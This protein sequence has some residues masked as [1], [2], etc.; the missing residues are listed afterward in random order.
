MRLRTLTGLER[1]RIEDEYQSLVK[2]IAELTEFLASDLKQFALIKTE[3]LAIRERYGDDR[4]TEIIPLEDEFNI[5]DMIADTE[6]VVT[7]TMGGYIKRVSV[8]T[9]RAQNRGG[10]GVTGIALK[11][12]DVV[13]NFFIASTHQHILF[14]T[15]KGRV[16]RL[17][18]KGRMERVRL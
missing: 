8:D 15:N 4:R 11:R 5:E 12:E 1:Q 14:F 16:Y 13:R 2:L 10:R 3:T 9:F 18:A 17:R 7:A 6:V